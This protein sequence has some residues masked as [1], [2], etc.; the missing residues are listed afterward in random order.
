L[1]SDPTGSGRV[2][3][4]RDIVLTNNIYRRV[5]MSE[6]KAGSKVAFKEMAGITSTRGEV[7]TPPLN[8]QVAVRPEGYKT[9]SLMMPQENVSL[10]PEEE[11]KGKENE[12]RPF[13]QR[14]SIS[15]RR[16]YFF[17]L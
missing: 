12:P 1:E 11:T 6:L 10:L 16:R 9:L 14:A 17:G 2:F 8:G 7:L 13:I 4:Y 3:D 5:A 15:R